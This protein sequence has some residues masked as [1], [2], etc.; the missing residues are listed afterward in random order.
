MATMYLL[1]FVMCLSDKS[2]TVRSVWIVRQMEDFPRL[3]SCYVHKSA[4]WGD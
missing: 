4:L 3:V 1:D 2:A